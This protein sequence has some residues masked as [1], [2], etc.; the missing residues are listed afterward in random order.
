M[1]VQRRGNL[2]AALSVYALSTQPIITLSMEVLFIYWSQMDQILQVY[3][4]IS[5]HSLQQIKLQYVMRKKWLTAL[6]TGANVA[7]NNAFTI[8]QN[9][10]IAEA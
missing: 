1:G 6:R 3:C 7:A 2:N 5:R 10:T 4:A 8:T 9:A